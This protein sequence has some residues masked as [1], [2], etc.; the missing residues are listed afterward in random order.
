M[1][2]FSMLLM[3]TQNESSNQIIRALQY[4]QKSLINIHKDIGDMLAKCI[5]VESQYDKTELSIANGLFTQLDF[6][7]KADY[8]SDLVKFYK[9]ELKEIN[10]GGP[11]A[12]KEV[13]QWIESKTHDKIKDMFSEKS[14]SD[15]TK[16]VLANAIYFKSSFKD[17]FPKENTKEKPFYKD[18]NNKHMVK[19]MQTGGD[20][21]FAENAKLGMKVLAIPFQN[22]N[23]KFLLILPT[24]RFGL[25][26]VLLKLKGND[27]MSLISSLQ[28][29]NVSNLEV[30]KFKID[31]QM[32]LKKLLSLLGIQDVFDKSKADLKGISDEALWV[33]KAIHKTFLDVNE[34]GVEAAAAT[35]MSICLMSMPFYADET[36]VQFVVDEPFLLAVYHSTADS[37]VFIGRVNSA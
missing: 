3:G 26:E 34:N 33:D 1:A 24:K 13:N 21:T 14:F 9:S 5:T 2:A 20:F 36:P 7:I 22:H 15:M 27:L 17:A 28:L 25:D 18:Y 12:V 16:L 29:R 4:D 8:K 31:T 35:A 10:F 30:P 23:F 19:M 6:Y 32:D 11:N 37:I